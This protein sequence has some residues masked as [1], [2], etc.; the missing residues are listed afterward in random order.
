[1]IPAVFAAPA[2]ASAV[3]G[4]VG[5]V[6]NAFVP[7]APSGPPPSFNPYI[8]RVATPT[9]PSTTTSGTLRAEDWGGMDQTS[10]K[11]WAQ[12]L[13]GHHIDATDASGRT[14]SGV[15]DGVTQLGNT[16]AL[17]VSGRL[18]SLS[19]LKQVSWSSA[20]V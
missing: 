10:V 1:M 11:T 7:S 6:M 2:V 20:A 15:V 14:I 8:D 4:V 19:Q 12:G 18:V 9:A 3:G 17:N 13:A 16:L 5:S